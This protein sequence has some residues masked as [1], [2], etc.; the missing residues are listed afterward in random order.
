MNL[1]LYFNDTSNAQ[2]ETGF[3]NSMQQSQVT[4]GY[5]RSLLDTVNTEHTRLIGF[6]DARVA[7]L[8]N[9][10]ELDVV[11]RLLDDKNALEASYKAMATIRTL[12]LHNF[13]R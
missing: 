6:F 12:S 13:L 10:D 4:L 5:Q 7:E 1:A 8:E 3:T 11:T 9:I 2:F